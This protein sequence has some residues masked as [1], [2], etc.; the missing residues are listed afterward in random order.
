MSH[1]DVRGELNPR[2]AGGKTKHPLY[3][4]VY[5]S[6]LSRCYLPTNKNYDDYGGR[7]VTVCERWRDD[8]W[9]FVEDMGERPDGYTLDRIDNDGPYSPDNCRWASRLE[10]TKNRRG[11]GAEKR[12]RDKNGRFV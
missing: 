12:T 2:W 6:M 10:Q 4:S 9:N 11:W 1:A 7:G 3:R 5:H 8:F